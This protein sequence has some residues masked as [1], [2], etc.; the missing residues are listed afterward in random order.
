MD[1]CV[2]KMMISIIIPM[3]NS[4]GTIRRCLDS[5]I[6]QD[7][8]QSFEVIVVNDGSNDDGPIIVAE[9]IRQYPFVKLVNQLNGGVS[10]ARNAGLRMAL[11]GYIALLDAD[12]EWL[13]NKLSVQIPYL[14]DDIADFVA[15]LRNDDELG[16]PYRV[17]NA[18]Y[19]EVSLSKLLF[20]VVGQ[21]STA[22]FRRQIYEEMGGFD[23]QQKYSEDANYWM[24]VSTKYR[25]IILNRKL[26][27]TGGG[28]PS[29][30]HSGLSAD[31]DGME[32]GVQKN[33]DEMK[34]LGFISFGSYLFFKV[35]SRFKYIIRK[36]RYSK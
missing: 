29:V 36:I 21:T 16:W 23:E 6:N 18:G 30:G 26:V 3:Y 25:M 11:G 2:Q 22:I 1:E 31:I 32:R 15:G 10:K 33:I 19:A 12:D 27:I 14:L 24:K 28:K 20:K 7:C 4:A 5:V 13:P 34:M 9:Y 17:D 8:E 35:Y